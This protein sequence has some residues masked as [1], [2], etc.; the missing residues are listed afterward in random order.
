MTPGAVDWDVMEP[1]RTPSWE[2]LAREL[3][4]L[5]RRFDGL[6]DADEDLRRLLRRAA[7]VAYARHQAADPV[8]R[9]RIDEAVADLEERLRDGRPYDDTVTAEQLAARARALAEKRPPHR[10]AG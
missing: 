1:G 4:D 5:A 3:V 10:A 8:M 2:E 7:L 6:L 9:A